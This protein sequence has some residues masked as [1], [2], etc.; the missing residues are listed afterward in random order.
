[1]IPY[2]QWWGI[3]KGITTTTCFKCSRMKKGQTNKGG[4]FKGHRKNK[5][6]RGSDHPRWVKDRS[7]L[8]YRNERLLNSYEYIKWRTAVFTRDGFKCKMSDETCARGLE[9]HHILSWRDSVELRYTVNNGI[10]LCRVHHP[11]MATEEKRLAQLFKKL[12]SVSK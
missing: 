7:K 3:Q 12:V 10:T 4:F 5:G 8:A 2:R 11:R 6:L 9:A 1:M